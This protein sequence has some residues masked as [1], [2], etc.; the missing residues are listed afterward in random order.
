[1]LGPQ[2]LNELEKGSPLH[3]PMKSRKDIL[4]A[5]AA[6]HS[7]SAAAAA[8]LQSPSRHRTLLDPSSG[9]SP[10]GNHLMA[11]LAAIHEPALLQDD[12]MRGASSHSPVR[13][14][15]GE[16]VAGD[17]AGDAHLI[18]LAT[19][20][21]KLPFSP[22]KPSTPSSGGSRGRS[23]L[24]SPQ[25]LEVTG[26]VSDTM[27]HP[28]QSPLPPSK[29]SSVR[30]LFDG[31]S[32][33]A[34][35]GHHDASPPLKQGHIN[36]DAAVD[37]KSITIELDDTANA[38][39]AAAGPVPSP[40]DLKRKRTAS[41]TAATSKVADDEEESKMSDGEPSTSQAT[42]PSSQLSP[43]D[44]SAKKRSRK[45]ADADGAATTATP[46]SAARRTRSQAATN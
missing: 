23:G 29:T 10:H 33:A 12:M 43:T 44:A 37:E 3:S 35:S 13:V 16:T 4:A 5:N 41:S 36:F 27:K 11:K 17:L 15:R 9:R 19:T 30:R 32:S 2:P 28:L 38:S 1:M 42:E 8:L 34:A 46:P 26:G 14:P 39:A 18:N 40:S 22:N 7:P 25:A 20:Q 21:A 31:A 6:R 24:Q 45:N